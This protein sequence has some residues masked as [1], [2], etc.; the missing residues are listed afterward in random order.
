MGCLRMMVLVL[1]DGNV[2]APFVGTLK[3]VVECNVDNKRKYN[4]TC[5]HV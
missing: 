2:V 5:G 4:P 1:V 3:I